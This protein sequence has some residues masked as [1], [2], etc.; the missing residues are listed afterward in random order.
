[1]ARE[2]PE[3]HTE[4]RSVY[5]VPCRSP[6]IMRLNDQARVDDDYKVASLGRG[7]VAGEGVIGVYVGVCVWL[8]VFTSTRTAG[9]PQEASV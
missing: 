7:G 8:A 2:T 3:S 9:A 5:R 6:T 1:M 4:S